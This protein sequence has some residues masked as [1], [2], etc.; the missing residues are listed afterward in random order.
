[1][2]MKKYSILAVLLL[3]VSALSCNKAEIPASVPEEEITVSYN[4][5]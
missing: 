4:V 2:G 1:M 3:A 5:S